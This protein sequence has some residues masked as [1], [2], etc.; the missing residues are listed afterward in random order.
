MLRAGA[1]RSSCSAAISAC[2]PGQQPDQA[3]RVMALMCS[4][5]LEPKL[6]SYKSAISECETR[7]QWQQA[8]K[9]VLDVRSS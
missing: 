5:W 3:L 2:E 7:E 6:L 4:S 8:T 1:G 9:L